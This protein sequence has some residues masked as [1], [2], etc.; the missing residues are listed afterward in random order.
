MR[1]LFGILT[2]TALA[3]TITARAQE[4]HSDLDRGIRSE[5][6]GNLELA[7][8][9]YQLSAL[10]GNARAQQFLA[11]AYR[12]ARGVEEDD[13]MGVYWYFV[14]LCMCRAERLPQQ[15]MD[16]HREVPAQDWNNAVNGARMGYLLRAHASPPGRPDCGAFFDGET[17]LGHVYPDGSNLLDDRFVGTFST[18]LACKVASRRMILG[19][20][21]TGADYEC[22]LNCRLS[23]KHPGIYICEKTQR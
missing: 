18:L 23:E 12:H 14:A 5:L 20:E 21:W 2:A 8:A 15:A 19:N 17:W 6:S 11:N 1:L 7:F 9:Y 10:N 3:T 4:P 13:F 16:F 22:G